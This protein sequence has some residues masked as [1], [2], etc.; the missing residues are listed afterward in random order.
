[1]TNGQRVY[2]GVSA[3]RAKVNLIERL[4]EINVEDANEIDWE[5]LAGA[6]GDVP[7]SYVQT[8]FYK[9]KATCVPFWQKKTFPEIID[10]LYEVTLPLLKEKLEKVQ[11]KRGAEV[12]TPAAPK[13]A[14]LFRDIF[15]AE[16]SEGEEESEHS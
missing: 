2:R 5:D 10:H 12:Q 3:L 13:Q 7:P 15:C 6:I 4:Y 1:M 9:L 8:K 16:D 11:E 14:F